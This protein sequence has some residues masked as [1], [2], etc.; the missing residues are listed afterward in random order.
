MSNAAVRPLAQM[1]VGPIVYAVAAAALGHWLGGGAALGRAD[2][3]LLVP[4]LI[5][6]ALL[7]LFLPAHYR[8]ASTFASVA[9]PTLFLLALCWVVT[10]WLADKMA[11]QNLMPQLAFLA[12]G[13][14]LALALVRAVR[15]WLLRRHIAV[16]VLAITM[17]AATWWLASHV[18][19]GLCYTPAAPSRPAKTLL[20]TSLPLQ[21]WQVGA[22]AIAGPQ[23][24]AALVALRRRIAPTLIAADGLAAGSVGPRDRLLLAHPPALAPETLVEVDRF[25]RA[26]GRAIILADGLSSWPPPYRLGDPRN[27]PVTSLLTPLLDHWGISLDAPVP[28]DAGDAGGD[29]VTIFHQGHRLT[30]HSPGNFA[31]LPRNC[32]GAGHLPD[33]R[34]TIATCRFGR[35]TAVLLADA[36]MLF[37]PLWRPEPLWAAH[38]RTSDNIEWLAAQLNAPDQ[39]S[40]W[41]LRPTWR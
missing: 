31:R 28:G 8:P 33:G 23:D 38:L 37:D 5:F 26:G 6:A 27:P 21:N 30:L 16:R 3:A 22:A 34:P 32:R 14:L 17:L 2:P 4:T 24:G 9:L 35:G 39:P 12:A 18:I 19:L 40:F 11:L 15:S 7:A 25:V 13:S 20:L 29:A 1:Y 41:G 10:V 36:D